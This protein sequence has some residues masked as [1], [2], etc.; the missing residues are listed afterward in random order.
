MKTKKLLAFLLALMF[1]LSFGSVAMAETPAATEQKPGVEIIIMHTND[2]HSRFDEDAKNGY[3]GFAKIAGEAKA[4]RS[5]GKN[6][7][8]V[9]AGDTLHGQINST[10]YEGSTAVDLLN[11]CGYDYFVPGNHDFNYGTD[12][13]VELSNG[14]SAKTL[15]ANIYK[16]GKLL[17]PAYSIKEIAGKKIGFFGLTTPETYYKTSA[18]NVAGVK[19]INPITAA[20]QAVKALKA[21]KVDYIVC[22]AH[23]GIDDATKIKSTDVGKKVKGIDLIIDGHSH[24]V[25]NGGVQAGGALVVSAGEYDEY[26]GMVT[27]RFT[28][29]G[30]TTT[31]KLDDYAAAKNYPV[32]PYVKGNLSVLNGQLSARTDKIIGY[33]KETLD[34]DRAHLRAGETNLSKL[35]ADI[36]RLGTGADVALTNGGGIRATIPAGYIT[37]RSILNV[38]PFNNQAVTIKVKGSELLAALENGVSAYPSLSGG[39]PQ[40]SGITYTID[41]AKPAGNRVVK[42]M[43]GSKPLNKNAV[44]VLATNDFTATGG[45]NYTMLNKPVEAYFGSLDELIAGYIEEH[46][47]TYDAADRLIVVE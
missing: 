29:D 25:L 44:Y 32:D 41:P 15:S 46:G 30:V 27:I 23:L 45:D 4:L 3:I 42:V 37:Y 24:S 22:I 33:T 12:R 18:A 47:V 38:F 16:D 35:T 2:T 26:V 43:V 40:V 28:D 17:F 10:L 36:L 8:L 39:F 9:D 20:K 5:A 34:G 19:F 1:T 21:K 13:L 14:M 11:T 6:V 31:A 7:V